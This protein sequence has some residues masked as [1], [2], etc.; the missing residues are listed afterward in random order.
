MI[1]D[2]KIPADWELS[3]ASMGKVEALAI[4]LQ[5]D[6]SCGKSELIR[7]MVQLIVNSEMLRILSPSRIDLTIEAKDVYEK[8]TEILGEIEGLEKRWSKRESVHESI[9]ECRPHMVSSRFSVTV[10]YDQ[11]GEQYC[12][13]SNCAKVFAYRKP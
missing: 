10:N 2:F 6:I 5:A 13:C 4:C 3:P 9:Q 8:L 1:H 11:D 12:V 7:S